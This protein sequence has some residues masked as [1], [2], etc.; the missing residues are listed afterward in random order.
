MLFDSSS[1]TSYQVGGKDRY[2]AKRVTREVNFFFMAPEAKTV[3]VIGDF[4]KWQAGLHSMTRLPDGG[5]QI[6]IPLHHG[7]HRYQFYVDGSPVLDPKAQGISRNER[8]ERVSL[9]AVS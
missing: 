7:H 4:N 3:C 5:W 8:N 9:M 1:V 2:S 6:R